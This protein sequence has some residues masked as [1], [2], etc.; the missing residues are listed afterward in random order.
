MIPQR[1]LGQGEQLAYFRLWWPEFRSY[2]REG[3]LIATGRLQPTDVSAVYTVQFN[4]RG[5]DGPEVR[6]V[7]PLLR[8]NKDGAKIPHMYAQERLCLY[9]PGSGE[10]RPTD[11]IALTIV[12]WTSLWL[13]F[14][15]VWHATGDW[16][17]GGV[18]PD[19][20]ITIRKAQHERYQRR[21]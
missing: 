5:G 6:V 3:K 7:E 15:E 1:R 10:W 12:P 4:Q 2:V 11:P 14:Y 9:L 8:R 21:K 19:I 17:G 16:L 13:Y 18:H 20:P